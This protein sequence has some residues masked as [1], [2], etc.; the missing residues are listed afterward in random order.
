M[1]EDVLGTM[2]T[3]QPSSHVACSRC[4]RVAA[5]SDM[6]VIQSDALGAISAYE[7]VCSECYAALQDGDQDLPDIEG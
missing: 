1:E 6:H 5:I 2:R 3:L 4:S 7:Q